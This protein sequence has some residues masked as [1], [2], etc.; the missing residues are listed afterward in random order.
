MRATRFSTSKNSLV[1]LTWCCALFA[2]LCLFFVQQI[3]AQDAA[4]TLRAQKNNT[5]PMTTPEDGNVKA[6][7]KVNVDKVIQDQDIESRIVR[8]LKATEWFVAPEVVVDEGVVFLRGTTDK[9]QHRDWASKLATSTED[10]VAVVNRIQVTDPPIWN[11]DP[12]VSVG[13]ELMR[14][15]V[16]AL[17]M[18]V[19]ALVLTV[20]TWLSALLTRLI[21]D[22]TVLLRVDSS[23][24][25]EVFRKAIMI[26]VWL[27][28]LYLILRISGLTRLATTIVGGT[29]VLGLIIG[30]AFR[31]I[32]ENFLASVLISV[33]NPFRYG[34]LIEV[35][36][37]TGFVQRVNTRGTLLMSLDGNHIQIPNSTIYKNTIINFTSN[38][39]RRFEFTIGIG[40]DVRVSDAQATAHK[41]LVDHPA[42]LKEPEPQVLVKELASS[43]V[44]LVIYAWVNANENSWMKVRSSVIRLVKRS[45][46]E[47]NFSM[48]DDSREIVFP[49]GVPV[50][51]VQSVVAE[52][53]T[54]QVKQAMAVPRHVEEEV[55]TSSAEGGFEPEQEEIEEQA[56]KSRDPDGGKDLLAKPEI[57]AT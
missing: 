38:P 32:A 33:Q 49:N 34:D 9:E 23:L 52:T 54:P 40:Y 55:V 17:P 25:R 1:S 4:T 42:V 3:Q 20:L 24:L 39:N 41:V 51:M 44:I 13:K 46:E 57:P 28:G 8:I 2:C 12:A 35:D 50:Q 14:N 36:G 37:H 27:I 26:P 11:I 21:A 22:H 15:V 31:D 53:I 29:G 56:R 30:F 18:L 48:P 16:L 45:F 19:I 7:E 10:V 43:T 5:P 47:Q 6:P